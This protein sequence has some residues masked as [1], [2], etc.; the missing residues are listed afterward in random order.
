MVVPVRGGVGLG[1]CEM[2]QRNGGLTAGFKTNSS[3]DEV[4]RAK[5]GRQQVLRSAQNDNQKGKGN[6]T[7]STW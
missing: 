6:G 3:G 7:Y 1:E 4:M 2:R 5:N